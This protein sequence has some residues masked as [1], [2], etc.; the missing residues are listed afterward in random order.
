MRPIKTKDFFKDQES[1]DHLRIMDGAGEKV[2]YQLERQEK[3]T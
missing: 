2:I 1:K 3:K